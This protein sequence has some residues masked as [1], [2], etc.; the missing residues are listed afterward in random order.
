[1]TV[2]DLPFAAHRS[3][4]THPNPAPADEPTLRDRVNSEL[5]S[6][7]ARISGGDPATNAALGRLRRENGKPVAESG[8]TWAWASKIT[9][10]SSRVPSPADNATGVVLRLFAVHQRSGRTTRVHKPGGLSFTQAAS[11]ANGSESHK[12]RV[13][14]LCTATSFHEVV[15]HLHAL[16]RQIASTGISGVDY[17]QLVVDLRDWQTVSKR[18][19]VQARWMRDTA[20]NEPATN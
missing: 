18:R 1:M 20:T 6:L 5:G 8:E 15:Q 9:G 16:V 17:A 3:N 14:A 10:H 2:T 13:R 11:R 7:H 12:G 19:V 4:M